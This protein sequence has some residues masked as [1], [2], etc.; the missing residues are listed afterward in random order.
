MKFNTPGAELT[1]A[2][3]LLPLPT[4]DNTELRDTQTAPEPPLLISLLVP[5]PCPPNILR[6]KYKGPHYPP[7]NAWTTLTPP[8]KGTNTTLIDP[9]ALNIKIISAVPFACIFQ[10]GAQAFQLHITPMLPKEHLRA[11]ASPSAQATEEETLNKVVPPEYHKFANVFSEGSTKEL[12]LHRT[13]DH[14]IDLKEGT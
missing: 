10:E 11:E 9:S 14:K 2:I 5:T 8:L 13:Y 7:Q 1:A 12:P 4:L 6:N 3:H